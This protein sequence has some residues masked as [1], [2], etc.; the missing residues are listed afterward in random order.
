MVVPLVPWNYRWVAE[1]NARSLQLLHFAFG[2]SLTF[3]ETLTRSRYSFLSML[4]EA[5]RIWEPSLTTMDY[6]SQLRTIIR[7]KFL[8]FS[9]AGRLRPNSEMVTP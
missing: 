8:S 5:K 7:P 6:N 1:Y 3:N 2:F 9:L 4:I